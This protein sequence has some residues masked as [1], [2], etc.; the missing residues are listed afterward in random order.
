MAPSKGALEAAFLIRL[1]LFPDVLLYTLQ[2]KAHCG[3]GIPP[4]PDV[5]SDEVPILLLSAPRDGQG[6][7]ALQKAKH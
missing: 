1:F 5:F 4:C 2:L 3:Y 7:L 6:T